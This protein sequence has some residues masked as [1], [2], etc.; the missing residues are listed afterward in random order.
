VYCSHVLEHLAYDDVATALRNTCSYLRPHGIFRLV[1]PDLEQLARNYLASD[2]PDAVHEFM[3]AGSLGQ[4]TRRR[5][6]VAFLRDWLGNSRHL[7]MWDAKAMAKHLTDA[8][9][10]GV[11]RAELGDSEDG[12]FR[13]VE[14]EERWKGCLGMECRR[15]GGG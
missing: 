13:D 14:D 10:V 1:L 6:P 8:G 5:G 9:F 15:P 4:R 3:E 2:R 7:W 12:L 11:R